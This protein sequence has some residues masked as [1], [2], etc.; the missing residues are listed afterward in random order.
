VTER[1]DEYDVVAIYKVGDS[2]VIAF[3]DMTWLMEPYVNSADNYQLLKNLVEA[4]APSE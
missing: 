3:G 1:A 2:R 4:I